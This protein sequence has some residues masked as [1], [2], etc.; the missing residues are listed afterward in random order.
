MK[1]II[2]ASD[3]AGFEL[4]EALKAYLADIGYEVTDTGSQNTG[5]GGMPYWQAAKNLAP[6]VSNGEFERGILICG[7][8]MG[9]TIAANKYPGVY[10]ALCEH[11]YA[12]KNARAINNANVLTLGGWVTPPHTAQDI[13]DAFL[14][15]PFLEG[16]TD[17]QKENLPIFLEEVKKIEEENFRV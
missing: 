2:I 15:T 17:W 9:M 13:V 7:T 6:H 4:K 10:A 16:V 3:R 12:A 8:G 1:K 14:N 5:E 11:P